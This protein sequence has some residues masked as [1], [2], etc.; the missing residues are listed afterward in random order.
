MSLYLD[1]EFN[2]F[3][4]EL[5]SLALV[6]GCG[7]EWY[8]VCRIPSQPHPFVA[9]HVLPAL[10]KEPI[11]F[12]AFVSSLHIFLR[13]HNGSDIVADWPEDFA[14]FCRLLCKEGGWQLDFSC[15]MVLVN[16]DKLYPAIPH[17]AL[18]DARALR[19]WH[20]AQQ[21]QAT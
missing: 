11:I 20:M 19:N 8:E 7:V 5:I 13:N 16:S 2:G 21:G 18:S 15:R 17:N 14:Y 6:S 12:P 10:G 1:T 9:Q 3:G 4:G